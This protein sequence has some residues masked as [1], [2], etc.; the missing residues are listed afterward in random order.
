MK[1]LL[2]LLP[3]ALIFLGAGC[4]NQTDTIQEQQKRI[5]ELENKQKCFEAATKKFEEIKEGYETGSLHLD[6]Y[7]FSKNR[8]SCFML[9]HRDFTVPAG[10]DLTSRVIIDVYT[11]QTID[12]VNIGDDEYNEKYG[13]PITKFGGTI[14]EIFGE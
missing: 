7:E 13:S 11:G 8:N 6:R 9:Y 14:E 2:F 5:D 4:A 12:S 3:V 10:Y 1:K